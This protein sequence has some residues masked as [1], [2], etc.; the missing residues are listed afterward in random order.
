[1]IYKTQTK[2]IYYLN[3][4]ASIYQPR[5]PELSNMSFESGYDSNNMA[6]AIHHS[7]SLSNMERK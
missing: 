1:M 6:H 3:S 7:L 4:L 5:S 2:L